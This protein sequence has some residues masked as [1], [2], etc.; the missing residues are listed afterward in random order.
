MDYNGEAKGTKS[1]KC[2]VAFRQ[3]NIVQNSK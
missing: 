2:E 1:A 3:E